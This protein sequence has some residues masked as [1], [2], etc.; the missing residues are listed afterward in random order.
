M[1]DGN[2][3]RC[4]GVRPILTALKTFADSG[5]KDNVEEAAVP[6]K[7]EMQVK[8]WD[9]LVPDTSMFGPKAL[10][11]APLIVIDAASGLPTWAQP[12]TLDQARTIWESVQHNKAWYTRW[13]FGNTS[14]GIYRDGFVPILVK[15]VKTWVQPKLHIDL[16]RV[17][18]FL[19]ITVTDKAYEIGAGVTY[20]RFI[21]FLDD[22]LKAPSSKAEM[23][24]LKSARYM[25]QRTAGRQLRNRSSLG[26]NTMMVV[27]YRFDASN[28]HFPS[29]LCTALLSLGTR[30]TLYLLTEK[31][32]VETSLS[33]FIEKPPAWGS[34][35][36][37]KYIIPKG[38]ATSYTETYKL[39][40]R[41]TM[42][43]SYANGGITMDVIVKDKSTVILSKP[44]LIFSGCGPTNWA[45]KTA[46]AI[47]GKKLDQDLLKVACSTLQAELTGWTRTWEAWEKKNDLPYTGERSEYLVSLGVSYLYKYF[48][49]VAVNNGLSVDPSIR[50][51]ALPDLIPVN[52]AHVTY[53]DDEPA[54]VAP[55]SSAGGEA[56]AA[57]PSPRGKPFDD[58]SYSHKPVVKYEAFAQATGEVKYVRETPAPGRSVFFA[59]VYATTIGTFT[60]K[61][62]DERGVL[63]HLQAAHGSGILEYLTFATLAA[64]QVN[65][66]PMF[67]TAA[68]IKS[69]ETLLIQ[70][71]VTGC[72]G[73]R[74][75]ILVASTEELAKQASDELIFHGFNWTQSTSVKFQMEDYNKD[76]T[77]PAQPADWAQFRRPFQSGGVC[78]PDNAVRDTTPD[79]KQFLVRI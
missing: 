58:I 32:D 41:H 60:Y 53:K 38:S 35:V 2:L 15:D 24:R 12:T 4:T 61:W 49:S 42:S 11:P 27:L 22:Q 26:G 7:W 57:S 47:E 9:T 76:P 69:G 65:G 72:A 48:V 59:W 17:P 79:K 6:P 51:I 21:D 10:D 54:S 64:K 20:T 25:A 33:D 34:Y 28:P 74:I 43:H 77:K 13:Q 23:S 8:K 45:V 44:I 30:V 63:A 3:C 39:A 52:I 50:D 55:D 14:T 78:Y 19:G 75:G 40:I 36:L 5:D 68:S 73:D 37:R 56:P 16:T 62:G 70:G 1:A 18:E 46:A 31:K 66:Q 71:N 29:D 67:K